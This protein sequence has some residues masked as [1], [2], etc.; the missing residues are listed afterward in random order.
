[1]KLRYAKQIDSELTTLW[2]GWGLGAE[3][4]GGG[5]YNHAWSGGPLTVMSQRIA[6]LTP[7]APAWAKYRLAPQLGS[8]Q[9]VEAYAPTPAGE[10]RVKWSCGEKGRLIGEISAPA[11]LEGELLIRRIEG[12]GAPKVKIDGQRVI[13]KLEHEGYFYRLPVGVK[14]VEVR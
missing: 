7:A 2:E 9:D 6:G 5:T 13:S 1:M 11:T 12:A 4:F 10:L 8:L 14:R 3:G